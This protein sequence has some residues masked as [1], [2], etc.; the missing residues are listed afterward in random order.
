MNFHFSPEKLFLVL[1]QT[2][3]RLF[4]RPLCW[5]YNRTLLGRALPSHY[6]GQLALNIRFLQISSQMS[7]Y[8][9][10]GHCLECL[11]SLYSGPDDNWTL[12]W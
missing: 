10:L 11:V 1:A 12:S 4:L 2:Q 6:P 9:V 7:T 8:W 3:P 5:L